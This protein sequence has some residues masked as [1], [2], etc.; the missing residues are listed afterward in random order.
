MSNPRLS[1]RE[2]QCLRLVAELATSKEIAAALDI[3]PGSVDVF[4]KRAMK[5][6]GAADRRTA[7]RMLAAQNESNL[8][9]KVGTPHTPVLG[10]TTSTPPDTIP[11]GGDLTAPVEVREDQA[12]YGVMPTLGKPDAPSLLRP[13]LGRKGDVDEVPPRHRIALI[14]GYGVAMIVAFSILIV[15]LLVGAVVYEQLYRP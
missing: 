8:V 11:A 12:V 6:L 5:K 4:I 2:E 9:P 15:A 3:E 1:P 13:L 10:T 7:A 14:L